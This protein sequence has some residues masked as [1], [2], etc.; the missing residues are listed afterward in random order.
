MIVQPESEIPRLVHSLNL[1]SAVAIKQVAQCFPLTGNTS[2]EQF[3]VL[4]SDS[5]MPPKPVKIDAN[6]KLFAFVP[7]LIVSFHQSLLL[8]VVAL[9]VWVTTSYH[10]QP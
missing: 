6:K 9:V 10:S 2:A 8:L 3:Q 1:I 4:S 7:L 5:N